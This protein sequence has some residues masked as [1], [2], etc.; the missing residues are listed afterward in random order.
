MNPRKQILCVI[1]ILCL[2]IGTFAQSTPVKPQPTAIQGAI[3]YVYKSINGAEL[4]LHVFNPPNHSPSRKRA[5]IVFFFGGGWVLGTVEQFVPQ[6]RHLAGRGMIAIVA[7][8]RVFY[9]HKT[10]PLEAMAD[11]IS[12]IRWVR[13]HA[14]ELGVD[15]NRIASGGGSAGGHIALSAAVFDAFHEIKEWKTSSKPNTLVLFNPAVDTTGRLKEPFG[16]RGRARDASP[17]HHIRRGLP[18]TVIFHG[19]ADATVPY[20]DVERFCAESKKFGNEC[21]LFGYEGAKHGFFN[22]PRE[23]GKWY[24]ETLLEADR[25]LTRLGY[26]PEPVPKAIP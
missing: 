8:Y 7:D 13:S 16:N 1:L 21:Q 20:I 11:A 24:R 25:F 23:Q 3:T 2:P 4:R 18:P 15:Q 6:S 26:L 12:A 22:P 17:L 19:K 5:A 14:N 9:R 10:S